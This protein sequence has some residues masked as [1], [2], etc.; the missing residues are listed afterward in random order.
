MPHLALV[1]YVLEHLQVAGEQPVR[2]GALRGIRHDGAAA[3]VQGRD[4]QNNQHKKV[5][6]ILNTNE[7]TPGGVAAQGTR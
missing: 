5:A 4:L 6:G 3:S 7:V 1:G 2:G